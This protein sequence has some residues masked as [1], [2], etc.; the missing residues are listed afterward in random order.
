MITFDK[1]SK[2]MGCFPQNFFSLVSLLNFFTL[3][4]ETCVYFVLLFFFFE[5]FEHFFYVVFFFFFS[6]CL[7]SRIFS[8]SFFLLILFAL[9]LFFLFLFFSLLL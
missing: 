4:F 2:V 1:L 9:F 3:T 5:I 8:F 7:F 6:V